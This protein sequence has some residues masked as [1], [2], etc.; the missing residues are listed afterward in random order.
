MKVRKARN[1]FECLPFL[2]SFLA[3]SIIPPVFLRCLS[4][5]SHLALALGVGLVVAFIEK[6]VV[7]LIDA[8][9]ATA[10]AHQ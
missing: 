8:A 9:D 1:Q 7:Q 3:C 6:L 4:D 5:V 10:A 2:V